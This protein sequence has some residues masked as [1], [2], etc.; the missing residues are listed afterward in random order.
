MNAHLNFSKLGVVVEEYEENIYG[1]SSSP[2]HSGS[3]TDRFVAEWK[4]TSP[5][6][7]W[8]I[9]DSGLGIVRDASV[10]RALLVNP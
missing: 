7:E 1:E 5:H 2:L 8:R 3:P 9:A 10:A 4:L 6:V